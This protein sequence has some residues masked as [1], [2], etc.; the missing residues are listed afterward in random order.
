MKVPVWGDFQPRIVVAYDLT[1]LLHEIS[2]SPFFYRGAVDRL[3][4]AVTA[5]FVRIEPS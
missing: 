3:T 5:A 2:F 4:V 1:C